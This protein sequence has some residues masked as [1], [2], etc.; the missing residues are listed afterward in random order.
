MSGGEGADV[1]RGTGAEPLLVPTASEIID[2]V[3]DPVRGEAARGEIGKL[4]FTGTSG[5]SR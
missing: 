5:K 2:V 4:T 3:T 1:S